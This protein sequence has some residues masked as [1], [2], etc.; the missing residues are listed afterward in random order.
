M[1]GRARGNSRAR[2]G[3]VALLCVGL[4]IGVAAAGCGNEPKKKS[5]PESSPS[6]TSA[7][8]SP[9][10][11]VADPDHAVDPPG[12]L[13]GA[14]VRADILIYAPESL[15]DGVVRRIGRLKHVRYAEQLSL[16]SV[17]VEGRVFTVG[18]VDPASYRRFTPAG[19]E[20][21][22]WTRIA[23]GELGLPKKLKSIEEDDAF[24]QLGSDK[25]APKVHV[26]AYA[27]QA[28]GVDM[29]V[30]DKWGE[31]LQKVGMVPGNA[32]LV[33]TGIAAPL[34]LRKPIQKIIGSNA[35]VQ[36]LDAVAR[37]GLDPDAAQIAVPS[38]GSVASAVGVFPYRL[39]GN[40]VVPDPGWVAANIRTEEVPILGRVTCNKIMF[41]QLRAA[42]LE[43]VQKH[44]ADKIY[45]TAGCYYPRF[46]ANTT[47]LS[48]HAFGL[49]IDINSVQNQ[50]G[51]VGQ[52]DR[53]VVSIFEKWG[54]TWGGHWR[55]TD[56]M[57]FEMNSLVSVR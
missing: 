1:A 14:L 51:T 34:S 41:P 27:E 9:T 22:I 20:D 15:S 17:A 57:H 54:F 6:P 55:Y 31:E 48:N 26:G 25:S 30:N 23:G 32:L 44:L 46:I 5:D 29:V 19:Q 49:A 7:S 21:E 2:S 37:F 28:Y 50:R 3:L 52:M 4:L 36:M 18:A 33:S 24:V 42:L 8:P 43:V 39:V 10:V 40:R 35:S 13:K 56:P 45:Q 11:P 53:T 12:P 16:A 38:G 47:S